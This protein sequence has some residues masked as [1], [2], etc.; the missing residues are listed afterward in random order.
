VSNVAHMVEKS[1]NA[2][3]PLFVDTHHRFGGYQHVVNHPEV[4]VDFFERYL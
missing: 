1:P 4:A 3:E 2:V